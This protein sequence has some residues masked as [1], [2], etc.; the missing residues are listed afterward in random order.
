MSVFAFLW[1]CL[2][3]NT[4]CKVQSI[5]FR[6]FT[7]INMHGLKV[8]IYSADT[9]INFL[10]ACACLCVRLFSAMNH[11]STYESFRAKENR[12]IPTHFL[13]RWDEGLVWKSEVES[14][15]KRLKT[16]TRKN[17]LDTT[18]TSWKK[19]QFKSFSYRCFKYFVWELVVTCILTYVYIYR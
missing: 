9:L 14:G 5:H 6:M 3:V 19:N 7:L 16:T 17:Y 13:G 8:W 11:A 4:L 18:S 2:H 10:C 12:E 1:R 15:E